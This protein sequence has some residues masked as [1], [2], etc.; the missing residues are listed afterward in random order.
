MQLE[1]NISTSNNLESNVEPAT[2]R[3]TAEQAQLADD[4]QLDDNEASSR[5]VAI[6][7]IRSGGSIPASGGVLRGRSNL[8]EEHDELTRQRAELAEKLK[9]SVED[10]EADPN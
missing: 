2:I 6:A 1:L 3:L 7:G 4:I 8:D 5:S 10:S 9:Q